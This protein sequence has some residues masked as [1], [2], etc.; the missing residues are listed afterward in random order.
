MESRGEERGIDN[1]SYL[2]TT[3]IDDLFHGAMITLLNYLNTSNSL[4]IAFILEITC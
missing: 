4:K 3:D 1:L 2:G